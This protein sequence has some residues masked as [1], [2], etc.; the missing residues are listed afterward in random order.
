MAIF[1]KTLLITLTALL[2][3]ALIHTIHALTLDKIIEFKEITFYSPKAGGD[4]DG[5][6][7]AFISDIHLLPEDDLISTVAK[8]NGKHTDLLVLGGDYTTDSKALSRMMEILSRIET[9]DGIFGVEGNH[10]RYRKLTAAMSEY[11]ITPLYNTG[12]RIGN[13]LYIAGVGDQWQQNADIASAIEGADDGDFVLLAA[14]NPD[15]AMTQ[16]TEGIDLILSGHTHGG[17]IT[18][19]GLWAP[20]F[21]ISD[22]ITRYGQRFRS[23]WSESRDGVPVYVGN[24]AGEYMLRVFARPQ[25]IIIT[26]KFK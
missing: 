20:Y 17:Q 5:Y 2:A 9:A 3:V 6:R 11:S 18:L 8:L 7:I 16:K 25:V 19:F 23:G 13:N 15:I 21:T 12:Y 26:L 10:D 24:G 4:L 22:S 1:R 14:H